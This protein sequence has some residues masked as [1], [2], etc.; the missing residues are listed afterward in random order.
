MRFLRKHSGSRLHRKGPTH[1]AVP[2]TPHVG[3]APL[4][5]Q[6]RG[7]PGP[8]L[9][10]C[11]QEA[12]A[13]PSQLSGLRFGFYVQKSSRERWVQSAG[14]SCLKKIFKEGDI[15]DLR[16]RILTVLLYDGCPGTPGS[17]SSRAERDKCLLHRF[18]LFGTR[19][20]SPQRGQRP[21]R[22]SD[23]LSGHQKHTP[24]VRKKGDQPWFLN[25]PCIS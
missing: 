5:P 13:S 2:A 10:T 14:T 19:L 21:P 22:G 6:T 20:V 25:S 9:H 12:E 8:P 16:I 23:S 24:P 7:I 3:G 15:R 4:A 11:A 18:L 1:L 17:A